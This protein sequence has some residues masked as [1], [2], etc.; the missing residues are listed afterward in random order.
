MSYLRAEETETCSPEA[1]GLD[2][3]RVPSCGA[4]MSAHF[5]AC[6]RPPRALRSRWQS[7]RVSPSGSDAA[8]TGALLSLPLLLG[9][10]LP[11]L[12]NERVGSRLGPWRIPKAV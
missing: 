3:N 7:G 11:P 2:N 6:G 4:V 8:G 1:L 5:T 12:Q 9:S 10:Q